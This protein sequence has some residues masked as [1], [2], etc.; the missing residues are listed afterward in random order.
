[1]QPC[2]HGSG[3]KGV[4]TCV[5]GASRQLLIGIESTGEDCD[6][7]RQD[8]LPSPADRPSDL[9]VGHATSPKLFAG[10]K[11]DL[12]LGQCL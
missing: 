5:Q 3:Q 11:A 1:V 10:E 8:E 7:P 9:G 6:D 4:P 2:P 12:L